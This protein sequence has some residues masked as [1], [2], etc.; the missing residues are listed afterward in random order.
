MPGKNID[1]LIDI[2]RFCLYFAFRFFPLII[3]CIVMFS[4]TLIYS[5]DLSIQ[6]VVGFFGS[7]SGW[8]HWSRNNQLGILYAQNF[9]LVSFVWCLACISATFLYR[10]NVIWSSSPLKNKVWIGA[11][12]TVIILQLIFC[13]V[14]LATIKESP[15]SFHQIPWFVY[16]LGCVLPIFVIPIQ[17]LVKLHDDKEFTRFQKRSKLEFSTKLGMHSPL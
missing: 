17:E 15:I 12:F 9:M 10:T 16:F 4:L 7:N 8:L 14:S 13:I 3:I 6:Q 2:K 5:L 11:F 1:H